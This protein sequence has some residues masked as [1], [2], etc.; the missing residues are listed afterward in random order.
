MAVK[1]NDKE[2]K[3]I[4]VNRRIVCKFGGDLYFSFFF[5]LF[6]RPSDYPFNS[7]ASK[8]GSRQTMS[9][10]ITCVYLVCIHDA[11]EFIFDMHRKAYIKVDKILFLI[12]ASEED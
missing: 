6:P 10:I 9:Q 3:E 8:S 12:V 2:E 1:T 4:R 7:L 11:C 5:F